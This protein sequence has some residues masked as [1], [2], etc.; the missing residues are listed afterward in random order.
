MTKSPAQYEMH[1]I[2]SLAIVTW[3]AD[4]QLN[5]VV[6]ELNELGVAV[7]HWRRGRIDRNE[8]LEEMADVTIMIQQLALMMRLS[9]DDLERMVWDKLQKLEDKING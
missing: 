5:H 6:E 8:V 1:R 9:H 4:A 3:G 7:N 2:C